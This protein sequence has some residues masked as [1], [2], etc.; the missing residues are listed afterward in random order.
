MKAIVTGAAG[1]LGQ[2]TVRELLEHGFDVVAL[3]TAR[4]AADLC[5]FVAAD[6]ADFNGAEKL[7]EIFSGSGVVGIVHLARKRFPYTESGF[8]AASGAW[9]TPDV[10]GD[11]RRFNHNA[12]I[13]HNVLSAAVAAGVKTIVSGSS[14]AVYGLFYSSNGAAP[15]YL[16]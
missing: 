15:D 13:T 16:P 6:L 4:P 2:C 5:P 11:A 3:D 10:F 1:R 7:G 8:D 14:L 9:K 12:A